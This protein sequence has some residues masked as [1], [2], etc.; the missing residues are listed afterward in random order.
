MNT[1]FDSTNAKE[2]TPKPLKGILFGDGGSR[3]NPG[4]AG[5]GAVLYDD[6]KK[7]IARMGTFCGIATNNVAEYTSLLTG[8]KL[9]L[10]HNITDL[11]VRMD[12]KLAVE[13]MKGRWKVKHPGLKPLFERAKV[14]EEKFQ[15]ITFK[16][17]PREKNK[18]AD[19]IANEV[20]DRN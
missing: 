13:Q 20:M 16:H 10:D 18:V 4:K 2:S 9:A 11:E 8:M 6:K 14:L 15:K 3:G 19:K 17:I 5:A 12:S 1:L 7:E